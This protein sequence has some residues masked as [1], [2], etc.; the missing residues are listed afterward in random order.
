MPRVYKRVN[1]RGT[2]YA[3]TRALAKRSAARTAIIASRRTRIPRPRISFAGQPKWKVV[4]M[5]YVEQLS[6]NAGIAAIAGHTFRANSIFDPDQSGAGHQPMGHDEWSSFYNHYTV[7]GSKITVTFSNQHANDPMV[8][9]VFLNDDTALASSS[10]TSLI[11]NAKGPYCHLD[12]AGGT[13][14]RRLTKK[15]SAKKFFKCDVKD[16][17][18]LKASFGT[19]PSEEAYFL[20]WTAAMNTGSDPSAV[21]ATVKI[22]YIVLMSEPKDLGPS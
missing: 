19:N 16:R 11:E 8:A 5:R 7:L 20:V 18:D 4:K 15:F 3:R 21:Y 9:G 13:G 22:D 14:V 6:L 10:V 17:T 2:G 1:R 12:S